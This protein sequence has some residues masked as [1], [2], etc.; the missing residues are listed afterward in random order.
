MKYALLL[1]VLFAGAARADFGASVGDDGLVRLDNGRS[2]RITVAPRHGGELAGMAVFFDGAWREL[3]YRA[4]DWSATGGWRGK[5]PFLWP[6]VGPTLDP[7]GGRRAFRVAGRA[8][9]MPPHGFARDRAWRVS[10]HGSEPGHAFATLALGSDA[11]TREM[12]PFDFELEAR[13]RL[14]HERLTIEYVVQAGANNAAPMPFCIGNHVTFR[15]PLLGG[16]DAAA[17]RFATDLP[18][19]LLRESDRT[20]AGRV[21]PSPWRGEHAIGALPRRSAVSLGGPPGSA[22][23]TVID[24]S[25][26]SV[27]LRHAASAEPAAPAIRFNLWADTEEGFFSPE[28]WLGTQNGLNTGAGVVRLEP[29]ARWQWRIDIIPSGA[30]APDP[31]RNEVS[32]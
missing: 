31:H 28:P 12:Y 19:Q 20:F 14:D 4:N 13:Y 10:G 11:A 15:A 6:A 26:L 16:G 21:V 1:L 17:V 29:G 30:A 32:P 22:E 24:P 3:V 18:D 7:D 27:T 25:G 8:Y 23:L 9:P 2:L 5:A